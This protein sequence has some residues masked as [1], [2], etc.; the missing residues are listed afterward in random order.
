M[1]IRA[2]N[3]VDP[4]RGKEGAVAL[5]EEE[6]S[7]EAEVYKVGVNFSRRLHNAPDVSAHSY[8]THGGGYL[9]SYR[10]EIRS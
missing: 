10:V 8:L 6:K 2:A 9:Q 3:M 4:A 5:A 1:D 7:K